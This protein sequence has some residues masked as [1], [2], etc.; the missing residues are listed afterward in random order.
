MEEKKEQTTLVPRKPNNLKGAI[1]TIVTLLVLACIILIILWPIN[2]FNTFYLALAVALFITANCVNSTQVVQPPEIW[3]IE[4]FGK[5]H[6]N[7]GP[8]VHWTIPWIETVRRQVEVNEQAIDGFRSINVIIFRDGP[9][10]LLNPRLWVQLSE[11]RPQN[12]IYKVQD[13][14]YKGWAENVSG[15]IVRG[16]LNTLTLDE[17]LDEGAARGDILDKMRGRPEITEKQIKQIKS[18]ISEISRKI[19]ELKKVEEDVSLLEAAKETKEDEKREKET[20]LANQQKAKAELAKFEEQAQQRG[21]EKIHRFTV[22]EFLIS[23]ELKKARE[24]IHQAKKDMIAAV[25]RATTE[26]MMRT[27]PIVR[28]KARFEQIGFSGEEAR[29]KA[30]L[31]DIIETLAEK[32][33]LFLTSAGKGDLQAIAAQLTAIFTETK[34]RREEDQRDSTK[35]S[36]K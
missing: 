1:G 31:I 17:A 19:N 25:S 35:T 18:F 4:R 8:G 34:Q 16:Y 3:I 12:A 14:D 11:D 36:K 5:F 28:A 7:L 23:E 2:G 13:G 26:A 20:L 24:S 6:R 27:E 33:S 32:R 21:F 15:P 22:G 30:F 9:A 10:E 29:E